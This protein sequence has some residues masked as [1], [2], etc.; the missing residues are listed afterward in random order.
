MTRAERI[1]T[2]RLKKRTENAIACLDWRGLSRMELQDLFSEP[3]E[4]MGEFSEES[5]YENAMKQIEKENADDT[6]TRL[7]LHFPNKSGPKTKITPQEKLAAKKLIVAMGYGQSR[8]D[9]FKWTSYLKLLSD[10]R[11]EE[12]TAFLL[13]RTSEFKTYF[14]QHPKGLDM[15]LS[16]NRVYDFPLQQFRLRANAEEGNDF[17]RKSDIEEQGIR[18]RLYARDELATHKEDT[19]PQGFKKDRPATCVTDIFLESLLHVGHVQVGWLDAIVDL[20]LLNE[21]GHSLPSP[22]T[23]SAG[24][25]HF[26]ASAARGDGRDGASPSSRMQSPT[27]S[28]P[29]HGSPRGQKGSGQKHRLPDYYQQKFKYMGTHTGHRS[30]GRSTIYPT[31]QAESIEKIWA[32][33]TTLHPVEDHICGMFGEDGVTE[34]CIISRSLNSKLKYKQQGNQ[35]GASRGD[36]DEASSLSK[37]RSQKYIFPFYALLHP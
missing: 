29:L 20:N 4:L 13:C 12:A 19:K 3:A 30:V 22:G 33:N 27:R 25:C 14:F 16:W 8:N 24:P 18:D 11:D 36:G 37:Y 1:K 21:G 7:R 2:E 15:L 23:T 35:R 17:S 26:E 6:R 5:D 28:S 32:E 31:N 34:N 10:L 9:I